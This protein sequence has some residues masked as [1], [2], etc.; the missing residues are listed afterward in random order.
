[1][2]AEVLVE[3]IS[4]GLQE[5]ELRLGSLDNQAGVRFPRGIIRK[6]AHLEGRLDFLPATV[7][8][9]NLAYCLQLTDVNRWVMN[10]FDLDLSAGSLFRKQ[11]A[12]TM[13]SLMEAVLVEAVRSRAGDAA[14]GHLTFYGAINAAMR[15]GWISRE[16]ADQLHDVRG[17][18]N[19][20]HLHRVEER[21]LDRYDLAYYNDHVLVLHRL[22]E[23]L[24][25]SGRDAAVGD[26]RSG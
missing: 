3:E 1:M 2:S 10:R 14:G 26:T 25:S 16:L 11:A 4:R 19:D 24:S 6:R 13:A 23:E 9:R 18:R 20:V 21:E 5:L 7:T 12:I 8:R 15:A 17:R 22:L